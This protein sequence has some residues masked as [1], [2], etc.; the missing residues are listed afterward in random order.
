MLKTGGWGETILLQKP[1][2]PNK[3][4]WKVKGKSTDG[5]IIFTCKIIKNNRLDIAEKER[6]AVTSECTYKERDLDDA[7]RFVYAEGLGL[8]EMASLYKDK[9]GNLQ[10]AEAGDFIFQSYGKL[11]E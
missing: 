11:T 6:M 9:N 4:K 10:V 7:W 3:S 1:L 2:Q 8:V 5:E